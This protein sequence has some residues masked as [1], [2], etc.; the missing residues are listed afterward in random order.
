MKRWLLL[1]CF[2][3]LAMVGSTEDLPWQRTG[4]VAGSI[5]R[6]LADRAHPGIFYLVER[7]SGR[8]E[9]F[10][11]TDNGLTWTH[12][13][14]YDLQNVM[15]HS[16]SSEL[17]VVRGGRDGKRDLLVSKDQGR[18]FQLRSGKAPR[19]IF[20]HP[21]NPNILW[22]SGLSYNDEDLSVSYDRG[23]HWVLFANLPYKLGKEYEI[24][25]GLYPVDSYDL[26]S[27]LISP[28]DSKAIYV[29]TQVDFAAGCSYESISLELVSVNEGKSWGSAEFPEGRYIYDPAFPDRA[30]SV[31]YDNTRVLT[32]GGWKR[33]AAPRGADII[34]V[35]GRPSLLYA[36]N[37]AKQWVSHDGGSHWSRTNIGPGGNARV[38]Q[39]RTFPTGTLLAGTSGA[40]LYIVDE[41]RNAH[42]VTS[43]FSQA[44]VSD[45]A[46]APGSSAVFAVT[47]GGDNFLFRSLNSGRTWT[48]IT[49]NL[50]RA[51]G[52][53]STLHV[54]VNQRNGHHVLA[55]VNDT[56]QVSFDAGQTWKQVP[57][58]PLIGAFFNADSS[59]VYFSKP[60]YGHL[61]QS[62]DGGIT[63]QELPAEF[64]TP[65]NTI[66]DLAADRFNGYLYLA[67]DRGLFVSRDQGRTAEQIAT[68]LFPDCLTC[69][70]YQ[71]IVA[72]PMR[73]QYLT[74]TGGGLYKSVNQGVSWKQISTQ[75]GA[76]SVADDKGQH[77]FLIRKDYS[78]EGFL[79]ESFDGGQSWDPKSATVDP[80]LAPNHGGYISALTDPRFRP[81][82]LAS[83][84]GM[85]R[86]DH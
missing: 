9:L 64:A 73:G 35:P 81:L 10:R 55:M 28:L 29:S 79:F 47:N 63:L 1:L 60:A 20:D 2:G 83:S 27:V 54:I 66:R 58:K 30:F 31:T 75:R 13:R 74:V 44:S 86:A 78:E 76:I 46:T 24:D 33:L 45:V 34:S 26:Q 8:N 49:D 82:Y 62:S 50:P 56:V 71:Q 77:L 16:A 7:G 21:T 85:F 3:L 32:A 80:L 42:Q 51:P 67:T 69:A 23:A 18:T 36:L 12:I 70:G 61:F 53:D 65:K 11:S 41:N 22:G 52:P 48:N 57:Q 19:K 84:R 68:D 37:G 15:V 4:P 38:L 25:G 40:G 43:G 17:F 59:V 5:W 39:S 6:I 72:L 14:I